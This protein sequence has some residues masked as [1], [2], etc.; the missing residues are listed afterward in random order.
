MALGVLTGG[1]FDR[2]DFAWE[3]FGSGIFCPRG[4]LSGGILSRGFLS[5][6]ILS[7][8]ILSCHCLGLVMTRRELLFWIPV[9]PDHHDNCISVMATGLTTGK[10]CILSLP[11]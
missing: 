3:D 11:T 6:G 7:G 5:G 1:D 4:I 2:G 10:Q 9:A 8:G